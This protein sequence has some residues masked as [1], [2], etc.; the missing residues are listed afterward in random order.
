ML[1]AVRRLTGYTLLTLALASAAL[2]STREIL[3]PR[4]SPQEVGLR[5]LKDEY[6]LDNATFERIS[7]LHRNYFMQC[8]K[9]CR[10]LEN[11]ERPLLWPGRRRTPQPNEVTDSLKKEQALCS[12]CEKAA[13]DHLKQVAA[14]MPQ[15]TGKLFLED[16]LPTMQ[17]QRQEHDLRVSS[18]LRR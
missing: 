6:H 2:W 14:L 11:A 9:M 13:T 18:S 3:R 12:D 1:S 8:K 10:Q 16:I 15:E 5:W 7:S 17:K 4:E